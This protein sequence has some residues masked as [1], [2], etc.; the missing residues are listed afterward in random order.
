MGL[1]TVQFLLA[2]CKQ[3]KTD[4]TVGRPGNNAA[5]GF[6]ETR[7]SWEEGEEIF[8]VFFSHLLPVSLSLSLQRVRTW[9]CYSVSSG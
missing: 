5:C 9:H 2:H 6:Y 1:P 7:E 4:W 8:M 3:S